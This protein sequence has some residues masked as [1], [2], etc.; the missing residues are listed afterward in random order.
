MRSGSSPEWHARIA[1]AAGQVEFESLFDSSLYLTF[2]DRDRDRVLYS[3]PAPL[4]LVPTVRVDADDPPAFESSSFLKLEHAGDERPDVVALHELG[5]NASSFGEHEFPPGKVRVIAG[6]AF[7]GFERFERQVEL[8]AD[9]DVVLRIECRREPLL[10]FGA[11]AAQVQQIVVEAGGESTRVWGESD[12]EIAV[13]AGRPFSLV[14]LSA[15]GVQ[16]LQQP[17]I[18]RDTELDLAT[19][20]WIERRVDLRAEE[21]ATATLAFVLDPNVG[22][23]TR[24][25]LRGPWGRWDGDDARFANGVARV[26]PKVPFEAWIA[27]EGHARRCV[28]GVTPAAGEKAE[29]DARLEPLA[30]LALAGPIAWVRDG[31]EWLDHDAAT[32]GARSLHWEA[33]AGPHTLEVALSDG[34]R[35]EIELA[36]RPGER[37]ELELR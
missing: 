36:L 3:G 1:D 9:V 10:R 7:S 20:P 6:G 32:A 15:R 12:T 37:R 23:A 26:P 2:R 25:V 30:Q 21:N 19:L 14:V 18:T 13:P 17:G 11:S 24:I 5:W 34:R 35:V 22:S 33:R 31:Q 16:A 8:A 4:E 28:I 29:I 27:A